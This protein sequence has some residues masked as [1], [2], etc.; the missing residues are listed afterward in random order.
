MA[1]ATAT[2]RS[3]TDDE[4]TGSSSLPSEMLELIF[5]KLDQKYLE[6][7]AL[8]S[9]SFLSTVRNWHV[10]DEFI[11]GF[12]SEQLIRLIQLF[13]SVTELEL[14]LSGHWDNPLI[15]RIVSKLRN[16]RRLD[17]RGSKYLTGG[18]LAA[19][20]SNCVY[21]EHLDVRHCYGLTPGG[22]GALMRSCEHLH[23]LDLPELAIDGSIG[24]SIEQ[25]CANPKFVELMEIISSCEN[26]KHLSFGWA[27][28]A[29]DVI[30][31]TY[32]KSCPPLSTLT[33]HRDSKTTEDTNFSM[34]GV[35]E[36]I[37]ACRGRL[38]QLDVELPRSD[39]LDTQDR[40]MSLLVARLPHLEYIK[41]VGWTS[42][43]DE[44]LESLKSNCPFLKSALLYWNAADGGKI[45]LKMLRQ[46][47]NSHS[48]KR[49]C[50]KSWW[51]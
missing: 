51:A 32:A 8:V 41:I 14:T 19:I 26:L 35:S 47:D 6:P 38:V 10:F 45:K 46:S 9:K 22:I 24:A 30:L 44:T 23:S 42:S 1:T 50:R 33:I 12:D 29:R 40:E 2:K 34:A 31:R 36:L 3:K 11:S 16:L 13:P 20:Y 15:L 21:L 27:F 28:L 43:M 37:H 4:T 48:I 17:L 18:T 49:K 25:K 7:V 5:S 39:K